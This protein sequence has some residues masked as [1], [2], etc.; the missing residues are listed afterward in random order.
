MSENHIGKCGDIIKYNGPK[1]IS[2]F[3]K[4]CWIELKK[5]I[6]INQI[7]E[8]YYPSFYHINNECRELIYIIKI[9]VL[10]ACPIEC[11]SLIYNNVEKQYNLK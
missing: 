10:I 3:P 2:W 6:V 11:C 7:Y 9:G 8:I 5:Y 4:S 1:E